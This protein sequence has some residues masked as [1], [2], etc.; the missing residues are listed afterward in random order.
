MTP[1]FSTHICSQN[2]VPPHD[3][4]LRTFSVSNFW[5]MSENINFAD[6]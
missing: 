6:S 2:D 5:H 1:S 4:N 3:L